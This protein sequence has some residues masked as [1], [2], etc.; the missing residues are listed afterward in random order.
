MR[1]SRLLFSEFALLIVFLV[2]VVSSAESSGAYGGTGA[3]RKVAGIPLSD[4]VEFG[5]FVEGMQA[6][7]T[8]LTAFEDLVGARTD[9]ASY[10]YGFGDVFP[11]PVE[12]TFAAGGTRTVLVSWDMGPTR[13]REWTA[14]V[15]D[16]YLDQIAAAARD[17]PYPLYVRPW[18]EMNGNWQDFQPTPSGDRPY[19]GTYRQFVAAWRHVV[20]YL[21]QHGGTNLRWV[22]NPSADTYAE[23][24]PAGEIWPGSRYVDVLGMDGYNWGADDG[25]GRWLSFRSIFTGQYRLLT[26]LDSRLPV[27]ICEFASKEPLLDDGAPV[28]SAHSKA[29]WIRQTF[30]YT[31]MPRLRA[32]VYFHTRKE[33]AWNVDSSSGA[34]G[35]MR[36]VLAS[37]S[38]TP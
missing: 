2:L 14:G 33:R 1:S 19:G 9:I 12:R 38:A 34:L 10:F 4:R 16:A 15:H 29:S 26:G 11:G 3:P 13:F 21:R 7:P 24:T 17:Y 36:D 35:A 27:W 25:W 28:D 30:A 6:D 22:F 37:R 8:R 31:G 23:T 5:A 20:T 32:V 18:P